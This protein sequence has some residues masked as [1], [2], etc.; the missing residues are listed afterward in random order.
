MK[1]FFE[2]SKNSTD[3]KTVR[4]TFDPRY[5][6]LLNS[7]GFAGLSDF[8]FAPIENSFRDVSERLTVGLDLNKDTQKNR[9]Y[10]KRHWTD[11]KSQSAKPH[12]EALSE[13]DNIYNLEKAGL[14]VPHAMAVG[15]GFIDGHSV[16]FVMMK[17]V[18]GTQADHF[19]RD[20]YE[21]LSV[22]EKRSLT[23]KMAELAAKFHTLGYNHRDFYLCHTFISHENNDFILNLIDLQR[24]QKRRVF[25]QRWIVKDLSQLAYSS[26]GLVS[27]SDR[28][29]FYLK[30]SG[31]ATLS[32]ADKRFIGLIQKKVSRMVK[33]E[34]EG[35]V[36]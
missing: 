15:Y 2:K 30:Y 16:G 10:L 32:A 4:L 26:L 12:K 9:V 14:P 23:L 17:E 33:R 1:D 31:N 24:V 18:P 22:T 25:R 3:I 34:K 8:I 20:N 13:W 19:I 21:N 29:R 36:R 7:N 28:L 6:D 5:K 11:A 27:Q 35:K